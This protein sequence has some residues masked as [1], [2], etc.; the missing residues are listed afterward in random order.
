MGFL[1]QFSFIAAF[2]WMS[3]MAGEVRLHSCF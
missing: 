3:A 2:A 1:I